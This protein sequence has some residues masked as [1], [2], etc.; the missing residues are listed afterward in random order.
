M[1][2]GDAISSANA[3]GGNHRVSNFGQFRYDYEAAQQQMSETAM[4][5][6]RGSTATALS[7]LDPHAHVSQ[8]LTLMRDINWCVGH[9]T[10]Q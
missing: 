6:K 10:V 4:G 5:G 2:P 3:A 8:A 1:L 7:A 9:M